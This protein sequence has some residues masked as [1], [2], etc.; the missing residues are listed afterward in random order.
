MP[1]AI[2][3]AATRPAMFHSHTWFMPEG[4]VDL[5]FEYDFAVVPYNQKGTRMARIHADTFYIPETAE[6]KDASW[7]VLKW[8]TSEENIIDVCLVYGCL[9]ARR[10]VQ[11]AYTER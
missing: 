11:D 9:P 2:P 3:S 5:P 8:L 10:S 4:L 7:E 6:N 1:P